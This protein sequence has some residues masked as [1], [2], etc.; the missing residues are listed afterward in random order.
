MYPELIEYSFDRGFHRP[1]NRRKLNEQL[2]H[3]SRPC[4]GGLTNAEREGEG[5]FKAVRRQHPGG[6]VG[7]QPTSL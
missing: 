7:D 4:K 1:D 6:G 3:N 5:T 2:E